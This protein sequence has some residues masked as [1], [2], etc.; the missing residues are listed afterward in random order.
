MAEPQQGREER[1]QLLNSHKHVLLGIESPV[2]YSGAGEGGMRP[3]PRGQ[4]RCA[5]YHLS[6][7]QPCPNS[8]S[9]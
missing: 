6:G 2:F 7:W 8:A 3:L 1:H 4:S 5:H 9:T